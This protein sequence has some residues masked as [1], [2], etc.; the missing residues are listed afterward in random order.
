M[1]SNSRAAF[2]DMDRTVLLV[3]S[4]ERW[5]KFQRRRNEISRL[6]MLRALSWVVRYKLA[7]LDLE[8]LAQKL[9]GG[10]KGKAE[11]DIMKRCEAWYRDEIESTIAPAARLAIAE[12]RKQG[13]RVVL[14]TS[15]TPW[16]ADLV[17]R[18]LELDDVLCS[19]L[20]VID[21]RFTGQI[22]R[23]LCFGPGKVTHAE[24]WA[25]AAGISLAD[26]AFYTDSYNDLPVLE[27]VGR[28]IV[29]NPDERLRRL[30]KKQGWPIRTWSADS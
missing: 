17:G 7:L 22:E 27:R 10:M 30:A 8:S 13:E 12:H 25:Q 3:D 1:S 21:G 28:P 9:I 19:R 6:Q 14:L 23:P 4:G 20:E 11:A 18:T 26:C 15:S 29:V 5:V 24:R 16:V 2:F